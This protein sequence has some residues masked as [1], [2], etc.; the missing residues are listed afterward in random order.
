MGFELLVAERFVGDKLGVSEVLFDNDLDHGQEQ[1]DV[2]AGA[3]SEVTVGL[4]AGFGNARVYYYHSPVFVAG[5]AFQR[6]GGLMTPVA[7]VG[8]GAHDQQKVGVVVVG[9]QH[10]AG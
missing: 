4:T 9:M 6:V 8:V 7:D 10:G 5:Q 1:I 3:D 2:R